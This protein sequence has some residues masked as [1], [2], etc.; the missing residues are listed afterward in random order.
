MTGI[1]QQKLIA[2]GFKKEILLYDVIYVKEITERVHLIIDEFFG[3]LSYWVL[4]EDCTDKDV[5]GT[6]I[7]LDPSDI[8]KTIE[9]AI[10][11]AKNIV[12][13]V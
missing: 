1:S 5:D 4:D 11:F 3:E 13:V 9:S 12:H 2:L 10:E 6:T 8:E 7:V